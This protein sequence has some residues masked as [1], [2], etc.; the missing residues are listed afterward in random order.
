M[1]LP[2]ANVGQQQ[3]YSIMLQD[4]EKLLSQIHVRGDVWERA[5]HEDL[6]DFEARTGLR[7]P[8]EYKEYCQIFGAGSFYF[9]HMFFRAS[10]SEN[11]FLEFSNHCIECLEMQDVEDFHADPETAEWLISLRPLFDHALVFG[12]NSTAMYFF[13][14]TQ[15]YS[16][17]DQS[18]DIY[19][20]SLH[21]YRWHKFGRSFRQFIQCLCIEN[22]YTSLP[23]Y[24]RLELPEQL[25]ERLEL[26][27]FQIRTS[28]QD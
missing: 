22:N 1:H 5:S 14:D 19:I 3:K 20:A 6:D 9:L 4:F 12:G 21:N 27:T 25:S 24:L 13:W 11:Y 23:E 18:Y 7:L 10:D 16:E 28:S 17:V 26:S 15:T 2:F 8:E